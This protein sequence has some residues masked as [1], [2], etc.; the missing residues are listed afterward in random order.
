MLQVKNW[1]LEKNL[2]NEEYSAVSMGAEF[3]IERET[4]KAYYLCA[5]TDFGHIYFWAPKSQCYEVEEMDPFDQA[6]LDNEFNR[7][8]EA[9][10]AYNQL[11]KDF[12]N[13]HGIKGIGKRRLR[14]ETLIEKIKNAGL[15]VPA[16]A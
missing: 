13:A 15:E 7:R 6:S 1:I 10:L 9:G 4:E 5:H 16:R 14:T 8:W 12:A 3:T 11:L 2:T